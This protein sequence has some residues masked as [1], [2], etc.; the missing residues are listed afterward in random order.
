MLFLEWTKPQTL[1]TQNAVKD[2][3]QEEISFTASGNAK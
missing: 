3:K 2:E 1:T